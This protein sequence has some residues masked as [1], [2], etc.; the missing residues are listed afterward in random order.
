[1]THKKQSFSCLLNNL[2]IALSIT[3]IIVSVVTKS[4]PSLKSKIPV[5]ETL[6]DIGI[7][8]ASSRSESE[9]P[10][11]YIDCKSSYFIN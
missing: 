9:V 8:I 5:E 4:S 1:M 6:G 3:D 7:G 2:C 11:D 10:K